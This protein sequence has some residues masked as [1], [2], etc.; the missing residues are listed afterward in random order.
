MMPGIADESNI[1]PEVRNIEQNQYK[2]GYKELS[3]ILYK[4]TYRVHC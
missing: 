2:S 3:L 1:F 4:G